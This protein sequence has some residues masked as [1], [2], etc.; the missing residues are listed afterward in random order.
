MRYVADNGPNNIVL[1]KLLTE[2]EIV[3]EKR[4]SF[5]THSLIFHE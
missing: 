4:W 2:K 3:W 1:K 5:Q